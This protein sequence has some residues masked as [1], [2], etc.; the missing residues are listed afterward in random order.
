MSNDQRQVIYQQR[1]EL[2]FANDISGTIE[3]MREEVLFDLVHD[4]VPPDSVEEQWDI[5][6]LERGI[7][8]EFGLKMPVK[9]WLAGDEKLGADSLP[10]RILEGIKIEYQS[11]ENAWRKNGIDMR[12]VE[13]QIMLQLLD[14][15]WKEHLASMDQLRQG[16]HLRAYA[17]KQPKQ[18]YKRESF[19]LFQSLLYNIKSGV[20]S[21]L[22]KMEIDNSA[23]FEKSERRMREQTNKDVNFSR[24][25]AEAFDQRNPKDVRREVE[26]FVRQDRK[27]GRNEP[28]P[29][30]SGKKYKACCGR[31]V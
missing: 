21:T 5:E 19:E 25:E 8:S 27:V 20:I 17:Q 31:K 12:L 14:Q 13:K 11:K 28:C 3:G 16:I 6:G 24:S 30:G 22:S 4:F 29:C 10:D 23:E 9:E 18:E 2:M 1:M 7:F 15:R 26:T